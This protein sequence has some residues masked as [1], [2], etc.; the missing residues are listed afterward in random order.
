MT[1][2]ALLLLALSA[3]L[4]VAAATITLWGALA[5]RQPSRLSLIV[6]SRQEQ[7]DTCIFTLS[8]P[9][10]RRLPVFLPGQYL[11][12]EIPL[13]ADGPPLMRSYSLA[14]WQA[15][16]RQYTLAIKREPGG[17]GSNWLCD[18]LQRGMRIQA[19]PPA[20]HFH[21][22]AGQDHVLLVAGGVGITPVLA[23]LDALRARRVPPQKVALLYAA[24][25]REQLVWHEELT[26]LAK[27]LPWFAYYPCLSAAPANWEGWHGRL[28]AE[29]LAQ[30]CQGWPQAHL[31]QCAGESLMATMAAAVSALALPG[32]VSVQQ[33]AFGVG[34]S[35]DG[36][37]HSVRCGSS[38]ATVQGGRPL[39]AEL[40]TVLA[41]PDASCRAGECGGCRMTLQAGEVQWLKEPA[42]DVGSAE[43]LACCCAARSAL[44][45]SPL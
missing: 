27:T 41:F 44:S 4:T 30:T 13:Q 38:M 19:R 5:K 39:L 33:E 28:N 7:A 23:M 11:T 40:E 10:H 25:H 37:W 34:G 21:L 1:N 32:G 36:A 8:L 17:K 18:Q 20:G 2:I 35:G 29:R 12:L 31:Y 43:I 24:R 42:C 3:I 22:Q 14:R 16:P 45:L 15:R 9:W 6:R 26:D